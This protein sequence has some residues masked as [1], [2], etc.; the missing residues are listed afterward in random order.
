M[1]FGI[2]FF[3]TSTAQIANPNVAKKVIGKPKIIGVNVISKKMTNF[4]PEVHGFKFIN[5]FNGIDGSIRW[6]G[7]CGG[8]V[9]GALDYYNNNLEIPQQQ[10]RPANRHPLQS[11][12]YGR[13]ANSAQEGNWD[14]WLEMYI[15]PDGIRN[16]EFFG[17]GIETNR[18][19]ELKRSIDAGKPV[20]L[21]LMQN[22]DAD[23]FGYHKVGDHQ[24]LAI[25]YD[26][27][28]Y[29]GDKGNFVEDFKIFIY[30]P[31]HPGIMM[32]LVADP[33][34]NLYHY[35]EVNGNGTQDAW[36]TYFV[37]SKY[38][39]VNPPIIENPNPRKTIYAFIS[40]G[41]DDLRGGNDNLNITVVYNDGSKQFFPNINRSATWVPK[42]V[43]AIPLVLN[44]ELPDKNLIK[45]FFLE[46]TFRGGI[47]GDNWDMM[48]FIITTSD[49]HNTILEKNG[50]IPRDGL[51]IVK[52]FTGDDRFLTIPNQ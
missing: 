1:I 37:N 12:L 47:D 50:T 41:K 32:T 30:D 22:N 43:E 7:L 31:N 45:E 21:G 19:T 51:N 40:T 48:Q 8:M 42:Y 3:Q 17:W 46:T 49:I 4:L 13:Q 15:N 29:N 16:S 44:R 24:V 26:F 23:K 35:L 10:F 25:G 11:Y 38:N 6:G 18:M 36:L 2:L 33:A 52:R 20:P 5:S 9:Y 27:G 39:P 28:R 14:K 34:H